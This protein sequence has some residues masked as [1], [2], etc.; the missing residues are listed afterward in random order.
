MF[1]HRPPARPPLRP[2][3]TVSRRPLLR[4][5]L[6]VDDADLGRTAAFALLYLAVFA[7][8]TAFDGV[9]VSLFVKRV[10]VDAL[11]RTFGL[12]ALANLVAVGLYVLFAERFSNVR[13]FVG[14]ALGTSLSCL[15]AWAFLS[16]DAPIADPRP[17]T[18]MY[19][20]R[21]VFQALFL[22]HFAAFVQRF[23]TRAHLQQVMPLIY[24]GGRVGGMVGG[25][26]LTHAGPSVGIVNLL[27]VGGVIAS[28]VAVGAVVLHLR[29][30]PALDPGDDEASSSLRGA[31]GRSALELDRQARASMRGFLDSLAR[32]PLLLWH[33]VSTM[34]YIGCRLVLA[35]QYSGFFES[36]FAS[37]VELAAFLGTYAQIA[38]GVSLV[39]QLFLLT[40]LVRWIGLRGTQFAYATA[41][42]AALT[43][44]AV[45]PTLVVAVFARFVDQELRLCLRNPTNQLVTNLLS[46]P[47]RN[48]LRCFNAGVVTPASTL[49]TSVAL[50]TA[51]AAA[52][53]LAVPM[54]G[55]VLGFFYL[56][57]N[58]R[59]NLAYAERRATKGATSARTPTLR[60]DRQSTP[61][62]SGREHWRSEV[63]SSRRAPQTLPRTPT[64]RLGAS[65]R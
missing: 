43:M 4:R 7:A 24:A 8:L 33:A 65:F 34:V 5:I 31:N 11:P 62:E 15:G 14:L 37:E 23:F 39:L 60:L 64:L 10:G 21:E 36:R 42:F 35:Y 53:P 40:R 25:V 54:L 63:E 47:L 46:R 32:S 20:A 58:R 38:L 9:A 13:V 48:R 30:T 44:H 3:P 56:V 28:T 51:S 16:G 57:S 6:G 61:L 26:L 1:V 19:A 18:F 29:F 45:H 50:G 12:V 22:L 52:W 27:L 2:V 41:V 49:A 55:L 17:Y 59:M